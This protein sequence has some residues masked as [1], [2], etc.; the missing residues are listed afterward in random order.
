MKIDWL[1]LDVNILNDSKIKLIR[2]YPD[3]DK[4]VVLWIGLLCLAMKSNE[5][6]L[7]YVTQGIPFSVTDLS[8]EFDIEIKTVELGLS[9]FRQYNMIEI[10]QGGTI[11]I[12]NFEKHQSLDR[13][14]NMKKLTNER[15]RKFRDKQKLICNVT[16]TLRNA[17]VTQQ[18]RLDKTRLD[19]TIKPDKPIKPINTI[20]T[21]TNFI[22]LYN[23]Y[24]RHIGKV[25]AYKAYTARIKEGVLHDTLVIAVKN[26]A[27]DVERNRTDEKYIMHPATFLGPS[28]RYADYSGKKEVNQKPE[29]FCPECAA[30]ISKN[31]FCWNCARTMK[32]LMI[33]PKIEELKEG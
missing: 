15:V 30:V 21:D 12:I 26:Y 4:L 19:K 11:E 14:E 8:N 33:K 23:A 22:T 2:N 31:S 5:S 16:E 27:A 13:I 28:A 25:P 29:L 17:D 18:I 3:G 1:K 24:P 32:G 6:G 20:E 9:L 10:A 7:I